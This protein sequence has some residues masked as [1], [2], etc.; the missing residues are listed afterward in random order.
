MYRSLELTWGHSVIHN[1][2]NNENAFLT[3]GSNTSELCISSCP[4]TKTTGMEA[5]WAR[6]HLILTFSGWL[7][8]TTGLNLHHNCKT[9]LSLFGAW[10]HLHIATAK[11][12]HTDNTIW[13][14]HTGSN[15]SDTASKMYA[16]NVFKS[17]HP[18]CII[19]VDFIPL[20]FV[21][22]SLGLPNHLVCSSSLR[23]KL[24]FLILP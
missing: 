12:R 20:S 23:C 5:F 13:S 2:L 22:F 19:I 4:L 8:V 7:P 18:D 16:K 10:L 9:S 14:S 21:L 11:Y 17:I 15:L 24:V 3:T 1:C 6:S